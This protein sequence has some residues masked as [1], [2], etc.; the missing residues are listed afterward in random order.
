MK[1]VLNMRIAF[2]GQTK[3][4]MRRGIQSSMIPFPG[5]T[6]EDDR[7]SETKPVVFNVEDDNCPVTLSADNL[8]SETEADS[9]EQMYKERGW[10]TVGTLLRGLSGR[11]S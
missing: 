6:T 3:P 11:L 8:E 4:T 9:V 10:I 2:D 1:V 5:L 7:Q